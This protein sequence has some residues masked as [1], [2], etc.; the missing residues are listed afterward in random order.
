[1]R[2]KRKT[3][4]S[5]NMK[6]H[7]STSS[8]A[9]FAIHF[10]TITLLLSAAPLI[11]QEHQLVKK[12]ETEATLKV[13]ESVLFVPGERF[14]FVSNVEGEQPWTKDGK[15]SIGKVSLDG[16]IIA[17]DWV[18]GLNGP[19]GMGL[20]GGRLYVADIDRVVVIDVKNAV[21]TNTIAIEGVKMLN[22]IT[23]D[24]KGVVYVSDSATGKVHAI[25]DG[26]ASVFLDNLKGVNGLLA[27]GDDFYVLHDNGL[28]QLGEDKKLRLITGGMDGG[29]DG[30]EK[31]SNGDLIVSCWRGVI[32]YVKP[33]GQ[34]QTLLDTRTNEVFSADIGLDPQSR[35]LYVP[36][37]F[38]NTVVAY[39]VR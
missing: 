32:H 12:W 10:V 21:I 33:D 35:T 19:K 37:F 29:V 18:S 14:L 22:D 26:K 4:Y 13:P 3:K 24:A 23:I 25:R 16:K 11:A 31:L 5:L 15:G 8:T 6:K 2:E 39:E 34:R 17:V 27:Q 38:K 36:T 1:L 28:H 30:V 7:I 20:H 9:A